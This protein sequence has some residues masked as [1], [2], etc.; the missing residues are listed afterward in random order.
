M[1]ELWSKATQAHREGDFELAEALYSEVMKQVNTAAAGVSDDNVE[2]VLS[3]Q[4]RLALDASNDHVALRRFRKLLRFQEHRSDSVGS[5]V[6]CRHIAGIF[7]RRDELIEALRWA[8]Q[9]LENAELVWSKEHIAACHHLLGIY[10]Q[11]N[12]DPQQA[13]SCMRKAQA[14]WEEVGDEN[15]LYRTTFVL[16]EMHEYQEDYRQSAREFRRCL[17]L[18]ALLGEDAVF[19]AAEINVRIAQLC[20]YQEDWTRTTNHLLAGYVR[21][22][23]LD[24][25]NKVKHTAEMFREL[26][27]LA[28]EEL[29]WSVV[30]NL[31]GNSNSEKL[32]RELMHLAPMP[33]S[34]PLSAEATESFEET[35]AEAEDAAPVVGSGSAVE[36][37]TDIGGVFAD[38]PDTDMFEQSPLATQQPLVESPGVSSQAP[39]ILQE[40]EHMVGHVEVELSDSAGDTPAIPVQ[41][42]DSQAEPSDAELERRFQASVVQAKQNTEYDL[43]EVNSVLPREQP[44]PVPPVQIAMLHHHSSESVQH[45]TSAGDSESEGTGAVLGISVAAHPVMSRPK[46]IAQS[47][48]AL[49]EDSHSFEPSVGQS[50]SE[51]PFSIAEQEIDAAYTAENDQQRRDPSSEERTQNSVFMP[52]EPYPDGYQDAEFTVSSNRIFKEEM[53]SNLWVTFFLTMIG[54]FLALMVGQWIL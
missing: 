26:R 5:S 25:L 30:L 45:L 9:A 21:Y 47:T 34:V 1:N 19:E 33:V 37:A 22:R 35:F 43:P 8:Q 38:D 32:R 29:V 39:Q 24:N 20:G 53:H 23:K 17:K 28:G 10:H 44:D 31:L 18:L 13:V 6:S 36:I 42:L 2:T 3:H 14:M 41:S 50:W 12:E 40:T 52:T 16:G 4:A 15:K 27:L 7:E 11:R 48:E 46:P 49:P 51:E 54:V